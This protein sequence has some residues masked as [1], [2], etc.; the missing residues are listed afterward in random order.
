FLG[1]VRLSGDASFGGLSGLSVDE[2]AG[3]R[4]APDVAGRPAGRAYTLTVVSDRGKALEIHAEIGGEGTLRRAVC[5]PLVSISSRTEK[6]FSDAEGVT[7]FAP[8]PERRVISFE[9]EHRIEIAGAVGAGAPRMAEGPALGRT[10]SLNHNLGLEALASLPS[11]TLLA[12]AESVSLFGRP[13]P[14]WRFALTGDPARPYADAS[15]PAFSLTS[16]GIGFGLVGFDATPRGDLLVLERFYMEAVGNIIT[17]GV[18]PGEVAEHASDAVVPRTLARIDTSSAIPV[19]NFEGIAA[20]AAPDGRTLV[21]LVS[22][23]NF[24][25]RQQTLL[26]L[27]AYDERVPATGA[28]GGAP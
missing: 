4:V 7:R 28:V 9:Q 14:V 13:H 1:G 12:G 24:S 5:S 6:R 15:G 25:D 8:D 3:R 26:Y 11:G 20:G 10:Q 21:W 16:S 17:V 27:F 22:D 19:D 18:V 2:P 23:D